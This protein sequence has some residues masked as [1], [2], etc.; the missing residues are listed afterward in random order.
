MLSALSMTLISPAWAGLGEQQSSIARDQ[1]TIRGA[2]VQVTQ[3]AHYALHAVSS[4]TGAQL[5]EYVAH[6]GMVFATTW[7]GRSL[8]NLKNILGA[9]YARY[10]QV[11]AVPHTNHHVL[12]ITDGDFVVSMRKTQREF[13]IAAYVPTLMPQG[14][15]VADLH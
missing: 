10:Q 6:S 11:I 3:H 4:P 12:N 9:H 14:T 8:P 1:A 7:S 2:T 13:H 15:T 5:H